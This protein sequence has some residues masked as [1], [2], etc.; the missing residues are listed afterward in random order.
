MQGE[1][2]LQT[3][4]PTTGSTSREPVC[5]ARLEAGELALAQHSAEPAKHLR[6]LPHIP[7]ELHVVERV[8]LTAYKAI[9]RAALAFLSGSSDEYRKMRLDLSAES[10]TISK[11][12]CS[13]SARARRGKKAGETRCWMTDLQERVDV[14]AEPAVVG[15]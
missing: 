1:P 15:V 2:P 6:L 8:Q 14:Q 5:Q 4:A 11:T 10:C 7:A 3:T 9:K 12:G 13:S